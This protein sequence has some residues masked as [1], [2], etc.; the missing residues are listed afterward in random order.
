MLTKRQHLIIQNVKISMM[1]HVSGHITFGAFNAL[2]H[3]NESK[4]VISQT[5][6]HIAS[7]LLSTFGNFCPSKDMHLYV[8]VRAMVFLQSAQLKIPIAMFSLASKFR[9]TLIHGLQQF[10]PTSV[11]VATLYSLT[12]FK[13]EFI[14]AFG[15]LYTELQVCIKKDTHHT[16]DVVS[17][18]E[19]DSV[20]EDMSLC[21]LS[22]EVWPNS[23]RF[24]PSYHLAVF[25]L[26]Q[27]YQAHMP[28][29]F[30]CHLNEL[31]PYLGIFSLKE[32]A[33][34]FNKDDILGL[35]AIPQSIK[36]FKSLLVSE[37][38]FTHLLSL[39]SKY[40]FLKVVSA[41]QL[42]FGFQR[43]L[44]FELAELGPQALLNPKDV[45]PALIKSGLIADTHGGTEHTPLIFQK[46]SLLQLALEYHLPYFFIKC[47]KEWR[48]AE[49][50]HE[51]CTSKS[52]LKWAWKK[53]S[54]SRIV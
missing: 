44:L 46:E 32:P 21:F 41:K 8:P 39:F 37:E 25:D 51:C 38:F 53:L 6:L 47:L 10:L 31:S 23:E 14:E 43:H 12:Y 49:S 1:V 48:Y 18:N 26:N 30:R 50:I 16:L 7:Q 29:T 22:W 42:T 15:A 11:S 40:V 34:I 9:W 13:R 33:R 28:A 27:W 19:S 17:G 4:N 5:T 36:K 45:Y 35:Y 2:C 20:S 3:L 52:L 54:I 24:P